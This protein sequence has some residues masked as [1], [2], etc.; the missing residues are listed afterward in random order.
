[1]LKFTLTVE[2]QE[3]ATEKHNLIYAFLRDKHL[4]VTEFYDVVAPGFMQAVYEYLTKP[5]LSRYQFSTIA[6]RCMRNAVADH[7]TFQNR[8][9]RKGYTVS[10]NACVSTDGGAPVALYEILPSVDTVVD[11]L[12]EM[13][14]LHKI[15]QRV[16]NRQMRVILMKADGFGVRDIAREQK[17]SVNG[18]KDLLESARDAVYAAVKGGYD[19]D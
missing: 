10:L 11:D 7:Y 1:M 4:G 17:M 3:F 15:A 12:E 6:Y 9:K 5:K 13:L 19:D 2:Q 18:V 16:S 14:L 8:K